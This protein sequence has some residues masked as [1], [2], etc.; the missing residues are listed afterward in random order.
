MTKVARV[1]NA[2]LD[3]GEPAPKGVV[4]FNEP[5]FAEFAHFKRSEKQQADTLVVE[6]GQY[7]HN[8]EIHN[9]A[10]CRLWTLVHP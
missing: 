3:I 5:V 2:R 9:L 4:E 1:D 7:K 8:V 10:S 6:S